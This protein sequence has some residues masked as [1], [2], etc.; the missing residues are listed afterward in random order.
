[1]NWKTAGLAFI[2]LLV[3]A[4]IAYAL[5]TTY[6]GTQQG[7]VINPGLGIHFGDDIIEDEGIMDWGTLTLGV[8]K[9]I[10]LTVTNNFETNQT[11]TFLC[12]DLPTGWTETWTPDTTE[13][14][15]GENATGPL[16]LTAMDEGRFTIS[17]Q[18]TATEVT[19]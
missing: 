14:A 19:T 9:S 6:S 4:G 2:A 11:I 15:P 17:W 8:P 5:T 18:I 16:T 10:T 3:L 1:M 13:L 7:D 12:S